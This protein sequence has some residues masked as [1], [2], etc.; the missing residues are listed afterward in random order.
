MSETTKGIFYLILSAFF[1]ALMAALVHMA[2]DI[3]FVEKAFFRN[4]IAFVIAII[5]LAL[6][7]K[8]DGKAALTIPKGALIFLFIRSLAGSVGIFGNFYAI[9]RIVLSDASILNKMSPFF[10]ILFSFILMRER[11]KTVPLI[12]IITAFIGAMLVVKPSFDFSKTLPT[13]AGF[14]GG[15]G[16]GLAYACVRKLG[17]LK[18]NGKI[19]VLFFSTVSMILCA[20]FM[21]ADFDPLTLRQ[22]ILLSLGGVCAAG[23]QF[24][25]TAAYYH[26]PARDISIYDYSQIIFS[27]L[28]GFF[29]FGQLPDAWSFAGYVIIVLMAVLNFVWNKRQASKNQ[30]EQA[31]NLNPS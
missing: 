14:I 30:T 1:F 21:I 15:A 8:K 11:I 5:F 2:G 17:Y 7:Y 10:A 31:K 19:I 22:F 6:D 25:I 27:T 24:S 4:A 18:C 29:M 20:P 28:L 23:G 26:A 3:N 9:D 16:A 13:A 12:A